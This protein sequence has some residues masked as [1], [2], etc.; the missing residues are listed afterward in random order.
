M[1]ILILL[2]NDSLGGAEQ[3]LKMVAN[4]Y[5][6]EDISIYYFKN[7]ERGQ[8]DE[9]KPYTNQYYVTKNHEI[10]GMMRFIV[11]MLFSGKKY[12]YIYTSHIYTNALVGIL[13]SVGI[14]RSRY[15]IARESTS[16]FLRY[17]GLTLKFY[18]SLYVMGYRRM[19]LLICQTELMKNQF[20][21]HFGKIHKRTRIE[22]I[23][24]PIDLK[25]AEKIA[26]DAMELDF[27]SDYIVTAG[28]L[29]EVKG[30]DLLIDAFS[31][32]K[33]TNPKL[34]LVILGRGPDR[35]SLERQI[36]ALNLTDEVILAGYKDNVYKYFKNARLCV[37]SSRIEGFP[38]V[39]LQMMSQNNK[40]VSTLCAGG[41][42]DID[43]VFTC[44]T[45]DVN[46]LSGVMTKCLN[47]NTDRNRLQFDTYLN[48][49]SIEMFMQTIDE[50]K[51]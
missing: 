51:V 4:F 47:E 25:I 6:G 44:P 38:N 34:K 50:Y 16:I 9:L 42:D 33:E 5:K 28:R 22:V 32:V 39:L 7:H 30:Y 37:I 24:N 27:P 49:R 20:L 15:F 36:A 14:L 41:I 31:V 17:K 12:D 43:G 46:A 35:E 48:A 11:S 26:S 19:N 45:N 23:P 2:P 21:E 3:Y 1:N 18:R 8:W 40:V 13:K 29:I 10:F